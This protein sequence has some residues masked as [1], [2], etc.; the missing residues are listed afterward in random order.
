MDK[1]GPHALDLLFLIV[2]IKSRQIDLDKRASASADEPWP[3]GVRA[4][5]YL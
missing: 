3:S 2:G 5:V 1:K 4:P